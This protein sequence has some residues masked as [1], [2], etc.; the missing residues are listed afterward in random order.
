MMKIVK[1][2]LFVFLAFIVIERPYFSLSKSTKEQ[3]SLP[4][5]VKSQLGSSTKDQLQ[6]VDISHYNGRTDFTL[7]AQSNISFVYMKA[8]QGTTYVD[9]TYHNRVA[10]LKGIE[11]LNGAYHF[12]EPDKDALAQAKH[13]IENVKSANHTLPPVL[14]VEITQQVEIE[15]IKQ[16]VQSWLTY[17]H[18]ALK[19]KPMLYS[20]GSFWQENLGSEFN[21]YPFWLADYADKPNVPKGLRDWRVWQYSNQGQVSG[22]EYKVDRNILIQKELTCHV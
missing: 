17:V 18:D 16:G 10:Q 14:D 3:H 5:N 9:P 21:D 2:T 20:Y 15:R 13:F 1:Y 12:F 8:T 11:L 19:C 6:G 7:L 4:L 22:I